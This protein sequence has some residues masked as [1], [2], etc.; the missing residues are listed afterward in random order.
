MEIEYSHN[1]KEKK[2]KDFTS[3]LLNHIEIPDLSKCVY[4]YTSLD[5]LCNGI[6][7]P[8][9]EICLRA[10]NV[11]Y[12]NDKEEIKIGYSFI[13]RL[14]EKYIAQTG[15]NKLYDSDS[16]LWEICS[17]YFI[18][19]F[20]LERDN[21][22]MW[23]MYGDNATGV[24]LRFNDQLIKGYNHN[25]W[26]RC[27]YFTDSIQ[28]EIEEILGAETS[29]DTTN[30]KFSTAVFL[31]V[32]ALLIANNGEHFAKVIDNMTPIIT[33]ASALKHQAYKYENEARLLYMNPKKEEIK[34]R[35]R[36]NHIIPYIEK[37]FPKEALSDIIVGPNNDMQRTMHSI[38]TYLNHIGLNHVNISE[39]KVPYRG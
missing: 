38:K 32:I 19:S 36:N 35:Y 21:L 22:P 27:I 3:Y 29:I 37:F 39:S 15:N 28:K 25:Q 23:G 26:F 6:I 31:F 17:D 24:A 5:A 9:G 7:R 2:S 4:H 10:T 11:L 13:E 1:E 12:L 30:D 34:Y 14:I 8:N 16:Y 20:S 33:F 18:T